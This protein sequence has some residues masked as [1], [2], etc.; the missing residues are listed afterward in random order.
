MDEINGL[1]IPG[2]GKVK[3]LENGQFTAYMKSIELILSY[4]KI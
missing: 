4:A 1:I 2:G 3:L